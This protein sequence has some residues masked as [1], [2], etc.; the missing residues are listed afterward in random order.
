[1]L[2]RRK[3]AEAEEGELMRYVFLFLSRPFTIQSE[4]WG[5]GWGTELMM[6]EQDV[7]ID[8]LDLRRTPHYGPTRNERCR[9]VIS[10]CDGEE[11]YLWAWRCAD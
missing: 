5:L 9:E 7:P 3:K 11:G 6:G 8:A 1:M 4:V 10:N 2:A